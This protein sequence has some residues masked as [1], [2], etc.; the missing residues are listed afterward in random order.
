MAAFRQGHERPPSSKAHQPLSKPTNKHAYGTRP[1]FAP[2]L[3]AEH[4]SFIAHDV[5]DVTRV[6]T[7]QSGLHT[8]E[9]PRIFQHYK[10]TIQPPKSSP[11]FAQQSLSVVLQVAVFPLV[12]SRRRLSW[13][14][15]SLI[16]CRWLGCR[17]GS[18]QLMEVN[19]GRSRSCG[20]P[21]RFLL[22]HET[23]AALAHTDV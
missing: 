12:A 20:A 10:V 18:E 15:C 8:S 9:W 23:S 2:G 6:F 16:G 7:V 11:A 17:R 19:P 5:V 13:M 4:W 1:P 3:R 14:S 21:P 22:M